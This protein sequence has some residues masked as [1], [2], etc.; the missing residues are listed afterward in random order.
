MCGVIKRKTFYKSLV[1]IKDSYYAQEDDEELNEISVKHL[2]KSLTFWRLVYTWMIRAFT[3]GTILICLQFRFTKTIGLVMDWSFLPTDSIFWD[4]IP[5]FLQFTMIQITGL[6]IAKSDMTVIFIG[7]QIIADLNILDD[8]I[9]LTIEKIKTNPNYLKTILKRH[10]KVIDKINLL[11]EAVSE[12]SFIQIIISTFA[13]LVIFVFIRKDTTQ[14]TGYTTCLC[15]ML[16]FVPLC[17]FGEIIKIKTEQLSEA[18]YEVNWYELKLK[19]QKTFLLILGMAQRQ[20]GLKAAGMYNVN[21]YA[22]IQIVK[23]AIS[24]CAI[25]Y[26]LSK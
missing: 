20:Y 19:D 12:L 10:C 23:L 26:T 6:Y 14:I 5:H 18:F 2:V 13:L 9:K 1:E 24:Y 17:L 11:N 8:Y 22:F 25:L 7:L 3:I 15:A 16:Q 21:I 4:E